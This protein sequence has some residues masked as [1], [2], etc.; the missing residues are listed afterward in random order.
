MKPSDWSIAVLNRDTCC[1]DC[2]EVDRGKLRARHVRAPSIAPA[3]RYSL[4]NGVALCGRCAVRRANA[5][6]KPA[7]RA[8]KREPRRKVLL[9]RVAWLENAE[10]ALR[11]EVE[12]LLAE[13]KRLRAG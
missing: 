1:Q 3:E 6:R 10:R 2:G 8:V 9:A 4:G 13:V 5:E 7:S 11:A 12:R